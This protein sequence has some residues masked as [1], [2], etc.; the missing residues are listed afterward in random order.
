MRMTPTASALKIADSEALPDLPFGN[1]VLLT[2]AVWDG[3][4]KTTPCYVNRR[5]V[6]F[7]VPTRAGTMLHLMGGDTVEVTESLQSVV[8]AL[9]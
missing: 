4:R 8:A 6:M 5:L 7:A 3:E 2:R 9:S 1:L